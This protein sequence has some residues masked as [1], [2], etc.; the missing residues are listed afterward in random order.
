MEVIDI[1]LSDLEPINI[2]FNDGPSSS[3]SVNFGGGIELLMNDKKR[4]TSSSSSIDLGEL[5]KLENELNE[6][7]GNKPSV[8]E[9]GDSKIFSGFSDM[10]GFGGDAKPKETKESNTSS[11]FDSFYDQIFF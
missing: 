8:T 10:F 6:L 2:S 5:D 3:S 9:S 1:G 7:S 4:A 11:T